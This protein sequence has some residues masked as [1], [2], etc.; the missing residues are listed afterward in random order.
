MGCVYY[1][2][3]AACLTAC[4]VR[5]RASAEPQIKG[6][7]LSALA[8]LLAGNT[9]TTKACVEMLECVVTHE[10][11]GCDDNPFY[12]VWPYLLLCCSLVFSGGSLL[13][14]GYAELTCEALMAITVFEGHMIISGAVAGNVV[15]DEI[16]GQ[17]WIAL[18]GYTASFLVILVGLVVLLRGELQPPL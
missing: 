14:L 16:H 7:Y 13:I 15:L 9:F 8:G 18:G 10:A 17:S 2:V 12:S 5:S 4:L 1:A 6:F 3:L 11:V